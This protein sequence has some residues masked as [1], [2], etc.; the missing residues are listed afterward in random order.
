MAKARELTVFVNRG[1]VGTSQLALAGLK[2]FR[3]GV[4][5]KSE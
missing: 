1:S 3:S 4:T 5:G 2:A